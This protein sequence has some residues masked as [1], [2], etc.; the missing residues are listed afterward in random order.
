MTDT[1]TRDQKLL[2]LTR[3]VI[4]LKTEKKGWNQEQNKLIKDLEADIKVCCAD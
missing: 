1:E 2:R 4:D 3:A